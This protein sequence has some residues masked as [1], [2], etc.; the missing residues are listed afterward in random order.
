MHS[1]IQKSLSVT[2]EGAADNSPPT[3]IN[4]LEPEDGAELSEDFDFLWKKSK[5]P[6]NS[7][8]NYKLLICDKIDFEGC[9]AI[10]VAFLNFRLKNYFFPD[11]SS[12]Y[13]NISYYFMCIFFMVGL[14]V[15]LLASVQTF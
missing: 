4:L 2:V 14:S 9:D 3:P 13:K 5:D 6:E 8:I 1:D 11:N 12:I 7:D 15:N 10:D